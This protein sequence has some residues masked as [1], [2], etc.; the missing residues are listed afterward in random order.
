MELEKWEQTLQGCP[1][2]TTKGAAPCA[3]KVART[4]LNGGDE[5]TYRK[6]TRL[7]PTQ[8]YLMCNTML[9]SRID[10]TIEVQWLTPHEE[11]EKYDHGVCQY[12]AYQAVLI[13]P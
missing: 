8:L 13:M 3:V 7:V 12:L 9:C 4:V 5:E 6:A 1:W 10:E 2:R 11:V